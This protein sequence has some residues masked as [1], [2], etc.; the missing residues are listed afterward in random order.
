[1]VKCLQIGLILQDFV[2]NER[3]R[4]PR[5]AMRQ[6]PNRESQASDPARYSLR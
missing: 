5:L 1:M 6:C 3:K 4:G 2:L